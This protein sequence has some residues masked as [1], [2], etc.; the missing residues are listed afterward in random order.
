[1]TDREHVYPNGD[2][3]E[4]DRTSDDGC[5]CGPSLVRLEREQGDAYVVVHHS[6]DGREVPA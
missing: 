3:I 5:V 4:H 2:V 1:M 6:L